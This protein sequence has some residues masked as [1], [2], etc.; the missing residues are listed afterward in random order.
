MVWNKRPMPLGP[1]YH[2]NCTK[3]KCIAILLLDRARESEQSQARVFPVLLLSLLQP[4][5]ASVV[6]SRNN[7]LCM[8]NDLVNCKNV[9]CISSECFA[10]KNKIVNQRKKTQQDCK[11]SWT[12][13]IATQSLAKCIYEVYTV[14]SV[15]QLQIVSLFFFFVSLC[16]VCTWSW[17]S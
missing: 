6:N 8:L 7:I 13:S 5:V 16:V 10:K 15:H 9:L 4:F 14:Y 3:T 17:F 1:V 11:K 2:L 12:I